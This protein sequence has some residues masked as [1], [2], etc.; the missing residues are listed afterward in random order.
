MRMHLVRRRRRRREK[1]HSQQ[2]HNHLRGKKT[3][4]GYNR[5][6]SYAL[7]SEKR[8]KEN[9]FIE[10]ER[11][12]KRSMSFLLYYR[13]KWKENPGKRIIN[14]RITFVWKSR[15][16]YQINRQKKTFFIEGNY[17]PI[18]WLKILSNVF[19][20]IFCKCLCVTLRTLEDFNNRDWFFIHLM[21]HTFDRVKQF[22]Y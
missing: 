7:F 8:G 19:S 3:G 9:C 10:I 2:H 16:L 5:W 13:T 4:G 15:Q 18:C 17:I 1:N 22:F 14:Y 11:E 21:R 20:Y 12:K 6:H